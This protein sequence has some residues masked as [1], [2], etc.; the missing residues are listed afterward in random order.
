MK[1]ILVTGLSGFI[2]GYLSRKLSGT[3]ELYDLNCDLRDWKAVDNRLQ[4]VN[5]SIIIHLAARTEVE[6]SFYEQTTFSEIN[7]VGTVNL[8]ECARKLQ[9]L[10]LFLFSSTMETYGWQPESDLIRDNIKCEIPVFTE[11]TKQNPNAPY[12]VAKLAC[13]EYLKYAHRSFD[14]PF[15]GLRQTNTYGRSD[16]D[17]FVVEQII[18]Q[19]LRN[20]NEI[21]LGYG[22]PYR[23]FLWINDLISLYATILENPEKAKGHFFCCGPNNAV[24]IEELVNMIANKLSWNGQINWN[25]KPKRDGEIY[26]LNSSSNKATEK[27]GWTPLV[28]LDDGL[29]RTIELWKRNYEERNIPSR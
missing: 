6:K 19:M 29:D 9:N 26:V 8:I 12:A 15:C 20:P 10:E 17:F 22:K 18:T 27:L 25:T 5:P 7:Y 21:N 2:G 23:N 24:S 14:F 16:N 11:E 13:E 28:T 1:K 4:E 3:Y